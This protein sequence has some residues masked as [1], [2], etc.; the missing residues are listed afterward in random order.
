MI[1]EFETEFPGAVGLRTLDARSGADCDALVNASDSFTI[2][3][4][5]VAGCHL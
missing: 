1:A 5:F 4:M 3:Q 2:P